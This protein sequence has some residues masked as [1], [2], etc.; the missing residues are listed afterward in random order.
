MDLLQGLGMRSEKDHFPSLLHLTFRSGNG[1]LARL[2]SNTVVWNEK[3]S[4]VVNEVFPLDLL[5]L[6]SF[7]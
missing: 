6:E 1:S 5:G 3:G 2:R 4:K 7:V